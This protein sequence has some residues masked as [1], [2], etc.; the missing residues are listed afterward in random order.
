MKVHR[1]ILLLTIIFLISL[2]D[3][4]GQNFPKRSPEYEKVQENLAQGWNTWNTRSVLSHVLLT[5][6][7]ALN[8]G[9]KE[10]RSG[11]YLK[12]ALIG[13]M[14]KEDE[15]IYPGPHAYNGSYTELRLVWREVEVKVQSA[16]ANDSVES[17]ILWNRKGEL[18]AED[19]VLV[20]RFGNRVIKVYGTKDQVNEPY[21]AAQTP[22]LAF[23]MDSPVGISTDK[24]RSLEEINSIIERRKKEMEERHKEF[25]ELAEVYKAIQTV[26][27]WDT[28]YDPLKDRVVSPVSRLW[29]IGAGGYV[30]FCWDNFF[31]GYLAS[32]ENRELA[33]ANVVENTKEKIPQGFVPNFAKATGAKSLDRSQ[34]P[35]GSMVAR[36]LYRKFQEKWFLEEIFEDLLEWN[37]WWNAY[38]VNKGLLSWGSNPCETGLGDSWELGGMNER[39]GAAYESGLDNSPMYD[40][41]PF[42]KEK[43]VMELADVGLTSLYIMDCDSLAE[44]ARVL[45]KSREEKELKSRADLFRTNLASLWSEEKGIFLN[46]RTD[47]GEF[48]YRISPTNFYPLL[49]RAASQEQA[50]RMVKEHFYNPKEFWGEWVMPSISRNDPAFPDN[51]YWRGRVWAP[52]NFLVYLGLRN[53]NLPQAKADLAEKSKNLLLKEWLVKGHVHENY[54]ANT[55]EGCDVSSSDRFYH[56]GGL[57]GLIALMEKGYVPAPE[58]PL[59]SR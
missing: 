46:Q 45:G 5:E 25:G 41:I 13:R 33:Y 34:P 23:S 10:Y 18:S 38:R 44:I 9:I 52:M 39:Q 53:Y 57:L 55:G 47:S 12:E 3:L 16:T 54:N 14:G 56:W 32:L 42:N 17:G 37:R 29:S 20:G 48:S 6:G 50:E 30:L 8:L 2:T 1:L 59:R 28:I 21:I 31:A 35:V 4:P 11:G 22:Y 36:E 19:G 51:D 40:D 27:A 58:N 49:A 24:K 26:L 43:H 7:F 15:V